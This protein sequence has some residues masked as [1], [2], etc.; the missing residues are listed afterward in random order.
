MMIYGK[1]FRMRDLADTKTETVAA[2]ITKF[3]PGP[4]RKLLVVGCGSG[5]EAAILA[6]RLGS[7]VS[8]IDLE[9]KFD[10]SYRQYCHLEKGDATSLGFGN[11]EFD[12][13]FSYHALEHIDDP[14]RALSEIHRVLNDGGGFWIGTPN[15]DRAVGYI[16]GKQAS[17]A[18][19]I[20][21]NILDW[22][23]RLSGRFENR[24][25]AHAGFSRAELRSMLESVFSKVDDRTF[26]YFQAVYP[27]K[28]RLVKLL[29]TTG[30]SRWT[31][32]SVYF[33]GRK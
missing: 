3:H 5:L 10:E 8:G 24:F 6:Q 22:R 21:W 15:R 18:D 12:F 27:S 2:L 20:G 32:P 1:L 19:K 25:G 4:I 31:Y 11:E 23:M 16:G 29:E 7:N 17:L 26:E 9:E 13:V 30:V 14:E 33:I 28:A